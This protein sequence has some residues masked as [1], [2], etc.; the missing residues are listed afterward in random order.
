[1]VDVSIVLPAYNAELTIGEAIQS[2]VMQMI[3]TES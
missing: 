1:M 2:I 3:Q